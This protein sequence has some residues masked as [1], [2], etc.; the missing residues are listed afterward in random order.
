M[1]VVRRPIRRKTIYFCVRRWRRENER[2]GH[3]M[4]RFRRG[5]L[6]RN[7]R[8]RRAA[9]RVC[10]SIHVYVHGLPGASRTVHDSI[11]PRDNCFFDCGVVVREIHRSSRSERSSEASPL[12]LGFAWIPNC[13]RWI[14]KFDGS[15]PRWSK[16]GKPETAMIRGRRG[17][18]W[19]TRRF[20]N[21]VRQDRMVR[22]LR[23]QLKRRHVT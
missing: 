6:A 1:C 13:H 14:T 20:P 7:G 8:C 2:H 16:S 3:W 22:R 15:R 11:R 10:L 23:S 4:F 19:P 12:M 17:W 21:D 18:P 9:S 5:A